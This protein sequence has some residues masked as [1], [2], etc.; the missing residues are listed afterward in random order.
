MGRKDDLEHLIRDSY[1]IIRQYEEIVQTSSDPKE[2]IRAWRTMEEQ[3]EFVNGYLAQYTPLCKALNRAI[4]EDIAEII[5]IA[6]MP[7]P[8]PGSGDVSRDPVT[9]SQE[10]QAQKDQKAVPTYH[11]VDIR[12]FDATSEEDGYPVELNV[13][14]GR[15]FPRGQLRLNRPALLALSADSEAYGR[16]LGAAL[17]AE[18]AI[19]EAY[20]ETLAVFQSQNDRLRVRLRLDPAELYDIRWERIYHPV[21]GAWYPL[22]ATTDTLLSRYVPVQAWGRPESLTARPLRALVVIASPANLD[23]RNLAAISDPEIKMWRAIFDNRPDVTATY[24]QSAT[25]DPPTIDRVR[26]ALMTGY[27]LVHFVCHGAKTRRGTMLFLEDGNGAVEAIQSERFLE[28]FRALTARPHLCF[29]AA[30][31]SGARGGADAFMPLGPALVAE[32]GIPAVVAMVD[33]VGMATARQFADQFYHRVLKHGVVDLAVHQARTM[34]RDRWDWSVPVLFSRLPDNQLFDVAKASAGLAQELDLPQ[35][36]EPAEH[37]GDSG[38]SVAPN[39]FGDTGRITDS[40]RFFDRKELLRQIFE[41]L[42]KGANLSLVGGSQVGKSSLLSMVCAL[43]PER[44]GLPPETFVYL[45]LEWVDDEHDFYEAL[46]DTLSVETCRGFKLTRALRGKHLVLCLD[47]IEKMAWDGFTVRVRSHL[48]GL[49]DGPA[50]PLRLVI[51]S[52]SPLAHLFPDSPELDSPLAGI[53]HQLDIGPFPPDVARAFLAQRLHST[54]VT[55]VESEIKALLEESG[56]HPAKLQRAAADL[57]NVR[58]ET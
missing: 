24:L 37:T 25:A 51:A 9:P 36:S 47:E 6:S 26:Q 42:G 27:H 28:M 19:G 44:M 7:F 41:E 3:R 35:V 31:E 12:I 54:G 16:K 2:K 11:L 18:Q 23:Q 40:D 32:G 4:P 5:V 46:C 50:A 43:G 58:R 49:A 21:A 52:R 1:D 8:A 34:V 53:C 30:C 56:G 39:P 13:P 57:Y 45:S 10:E 38:G 29:L 20:Q 15:D 48:R 33:R 14:G 22:A 55:F 17:F